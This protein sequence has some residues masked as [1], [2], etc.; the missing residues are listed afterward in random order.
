MKKRVIELKI[1][2]LMLLSGI[3]LMSVVS[4]GLW[5]WISESITGKVTEQ[6]VVLNI[7]IGGGNAPNIVYLGNNSINVSGGLNEGSATN[8]RV[9]LTVSDSE[10]ASNINSSSVTINFS[11]SG[12]D[13]RAN[14]SCYEFASESTASTKNF[15]CTVTM[16]WWDGAGAWSVVAFAKDVNNNIALNT[17]TTFSVGTTTGFV[18]SPSALTWA[19]I[20]A[21]AYNQTS[22]NDPLLMNN[23]GNVDIAVESIQVNATN[24]LGEQDDTKALW[25]SN[26]SVGPNTGSSAECAATSMVHGDYTGIAAANLSAGNYTKNYGNES[27]GQEQLYFCLKKAGAE[28]TAQSYSTAKTGSWTVK[29]A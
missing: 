16:W 9:N 27:S 28:L 2:S 25:A 5:G 23:T 26:F 13:T 6:N 21:S 12:E 7:T 14:V 1:I 22:N 18:S 8:I 24:L 20:N 11:R 15:T 17:T 10:G 19:Q 29:I 3:F 4:A